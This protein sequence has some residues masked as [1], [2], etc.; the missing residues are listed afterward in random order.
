MKEKPTDSSHKDEK[1]AFDRRF[2]RAVIAFAVVEFIVIAFSVYY[3][4]TR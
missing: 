3:K 1:A 2:K 4:I